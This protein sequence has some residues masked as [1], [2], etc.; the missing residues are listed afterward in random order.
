[1]GVS[2]NTTLFHDIVVLGLTGYAIRVWAIDHRIGD[3]S[4]SFLPNGAFRYKPFSLIGPCLTSAI[5]F[6]FLLALMRK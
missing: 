5:I 1:M 6:S 3:R 4:Y 2:I